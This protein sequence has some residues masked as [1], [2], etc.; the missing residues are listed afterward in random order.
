MLFRLGY[1]ILSCVPLVYSGDISNSDIEKTLGP[2][3]SHHIFNGALLVAKNGTIIHR[4]GYGLANR[5]WKNENTSQTRYRIAS[6]SKSLTAILVIRLIQEGKL[7]LDDNIGQFLPD[8]PEDK[9]S[10]ITIHH[11]LSHS[12][13]I[14][15]YI[16]IPGWFEGHFRRDIGSN[17]WMD[18]IANLELDFKP[19]SSTRYSNSGYF[20]LGKIV[21]QIERKPFENVLRSKVLDP[22]GMK[23]TAPDRSKTILDQRAAGY[24]LNETGGYK[25]QG[26]LN[27]GLFT[28]TADLVSTVSDLFLLDQGLYGQK[29]LSEASKAVLFHPTQSYGWNVEQRKLDGHENLVKTIN[30]N[31]QIDGHSSMLT[32]FVDHGHCVVILSN[33]A[34]SYAQKRRLTEEI[35]LVLLGQKRESSP[36]DGTFLLNKKIVEGKPIGEA[37]Q[38]FRTPEGRYRV[39]D[40]SIVEYARNLGE[41]GLKEFAFQ[42]LKESGDRFPESAPVHFYLG[43]SLA[44]RKQDQAAIKHYRIALSLLPDNPQIM[45]ALKALGVS[46]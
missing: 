19:G 13:G 37:F 1:I 45:D 42:V 34:M 36:I 31:G 44:E 38:E 18:L 4:K 12:S 10:S 20:I 3:V 11:L 26:Y 5:E 25:N 33:N 23:H 8:F 14:P 27:M 35:A 22:L 21:E 28:A 32:R 17:E 43:K 7:G 6:M 9:G 30:Y 41:F 46:P 29:V 39:E 40:T 16:S 24:V 2:Y 15:H